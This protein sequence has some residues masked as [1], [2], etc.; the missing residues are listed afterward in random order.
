MSSSTIATSTARSISGSNIWLDLSLATQSPR[1]MSFGQAD[2]EQCSALNV[3]RLQNDISLFKS[4]QLDAVRLTRA[5]QKLLLRPLQCSPLY[6]ANGIPSVQTGR[7]RFGRALLIRV[8]ELAS[9]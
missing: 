8:K 2:G 5:F 6:L 7:A 1:S 9:I 3:S 4:S